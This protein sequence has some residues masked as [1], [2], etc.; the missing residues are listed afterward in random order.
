MPLPDPLPDNPQR[1]DGWKNYNSPN[2]YERLCL[3]FAANVTDE[4]IE[5]HCRQLLVWWQKKLP[6]KNQ[7]SNPLTQLLRGGLDEAPG[8]LAEAR[9]MLLNAESRS[10]L[11]QELRQRFIDEASQEL[12][13]I[14]PFAAVN[15]LL[16]A[17]AVA[18]L[19]QTGL[20]LGLTAQQ[21][22]GVI[23]AEAGRLGLV[24]GEPPAPEPAPAAAAPT[25]APAA[26]PSTSDPFAEFRRLLRMSRLALDGEEMSDSQRDAMCNL[27]ESLGLTGGQAEDLIDEYLDEVSGMPPAPMPAPA[28]VAAQK[29]AAQKVAA[30]KVAAQKGAAP[31]PAVPA[32]KPSSVVLPPRPAFVVPTPAMRAQERE[33]N[34]NFTNRL[35]IEMRLVGSGQFTMGS[36]GAEATPQEQPLTRVSISA[37]YMARFPVTNRQYECFD[38]SHSRKRPPWAGDE[39]PVV[40][41][42][43]REAEKFC[44]WLSSQEGRKY[45]LPSEAE[46]EYAARGPQGSTFPWGER[47]DAGCYAN[48]AD[49]NTQ[50]AWRNAQIDDGHAEG[51]PVGSYPRGASHFGIEDLAGNVFEWCLDYF[52]PYRGREVI[53]RRG[54]ASGS[55]RIYRGGSWRS[56][57]SSLRGSARAYNAP[58]YSSNDV[59]FRIVCEAS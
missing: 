44:Q 59:G 19:A 40:Y 1:W 56:K 36:V 49:L 37:F 2:F 38:P 33:R 51:A 41:V 3:D 22:A 4:Q 28:P 27:G 52:E 21:T 29:V 13:K 20:D 5:D 54:A 10:R 16:S 50:F 35:G 26:G 14:I 58:E 18:R 48:F 17:E 7:P 53:N 23:E 24:R 39:H 31:R 47:L 55:Q 46:W 57:A 25:P 6:L 34:P 8:L 32:A 45:R 15:G 43:S 42:S 9:T 30:Q 11:D 12:R